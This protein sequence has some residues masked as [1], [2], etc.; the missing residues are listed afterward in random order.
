MTKEEIKILQARVSGE[1]LKELIKKSGYT[2]YRIAKECN[3]S[4]RS[5]LYWEAGRIPSEKIALILGFYF[6]VISPDE[7]EVENLKVEMKELK[8]KIDRMTA[9]QTDEKIFAA[10][11]REKDRRG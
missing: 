4:Y 2:K 10:M 5:L 11:E 9:G 7:K 1:G 3:V 6:G 8:A